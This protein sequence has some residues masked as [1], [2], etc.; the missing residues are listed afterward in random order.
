LL[1]KGFRKNGSTFQ[2]CSLLSLPGWEMRSLPKREAHLRESETQRTFYPG[3]ATFVAG[4][5]MLRMRQPSCPTPTPRNDPLV[6]VPLDGAE[7]KSEDYQ[8]AIRRDAVQ[9]P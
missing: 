8:R 3:P 7:T 9:I 6:E 5:S 1:T 2:F 4:A